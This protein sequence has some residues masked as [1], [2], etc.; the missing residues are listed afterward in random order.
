MLY[1]KES[2]DGTE[3]YGDGKMLP[4]TVS[5]TNFHKE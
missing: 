1:C 4:E 2:L 3:G 5:K